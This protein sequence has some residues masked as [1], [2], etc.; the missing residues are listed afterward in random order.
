MNRQARIVSVFSAT[1]L[2]GGSVVRSLLNDK[3]SGFKVRGI[4][5]DPA[6]DKARALEK[7]GVELAKADGWHEHQVRDAVAGSWAVFV[8]TNSDDPVCGYHS[9]R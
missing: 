7:L 2:Q 5:R 9:G 6:S 1:G 3:V 8:N 4:T